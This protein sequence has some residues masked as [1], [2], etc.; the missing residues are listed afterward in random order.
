MASQVGTP[1]PVIRR[2]V[3]LLPQWKFERNAAMILL[4]DLLDN[5]VCGLGSWDLAVDDRVV[6]I[7][8]EILVNNSKTRR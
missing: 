3:R 5:H 7:N 8:F 6:L 4:R 1:K 2:V